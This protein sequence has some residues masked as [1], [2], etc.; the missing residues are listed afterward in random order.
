[1]RAVEID[2]RAWLQ[3]SIVL[4]NLAR[5]RV[6]DTASVAASNPQNPPFAARPVH[7]FRVKLKEIDLFSPA[8]TSSLPLIVANVPLAGHQFSDF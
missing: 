2:A 8:V 5:V 3:R 7:F 4:T 1:M 6:R